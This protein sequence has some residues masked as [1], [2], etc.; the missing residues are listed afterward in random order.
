MNAPRNQP[1]SNPSGDMLASDDL[2]PHPS[3]TSPAHTEMWTL[4]E[5][6]MPDRYH[7]ER[8]LPESVMADS[9]AP[10]AP[11]TKE[12]FATG[13]LPAGT[14]LGHFVIKSFIGGGGMGRVY[15]ATDK[16][17]D[18][19]VAIKVLTR[20]KANDR[21]TVARFVNE[22]KSAARLNHEHI[23]QV[24]FT[25]E[26]AGIPYIVFEYVEGTNIRSMVE[27]FDAFPLPQ[28]LNYLIQVAHALGHAAEHG[29]I[30][31][32]IKPSNILI[33]RE[34][35]A[36]LIDMGLARLLHPSESQDDLTASGVTLGTF[37]YIS[38]EQARDPRNA[39]IRSDI[40]SL[41]C[42][43]FYMLCG[44]P[45]FPEGTVLQKLLQHQGDEPP[46]V[47]EF[48]P[49]IPAEVAGLIQKMMAKDP[50]LRFQTPHAL[51]ESL[52]S[53]A[54]M[55][56]LQPSGPG[57]LHW[58]GP[59]PTRSSVLLHHLPWVL[60]ITLLLAA[61]FLL[62]LFS[63]PQR[64]L[65]PPPE[66]IVPPP[67]TA[68]NPASS[69]SHSGADSFP[70][71]ASGS[72]AGSGNGTTQIRTVADTLP[73]FPVESYT[74]ARFSPPNHANLRRVSYRAGLNHSGRGVGPAPLSSVSVGLSQT[75]PPPA[76][77]L[78]ILDC[79]NALGPNASPTAISL[80]S[81]SATASTELQ[82]LCVDPDGVESASPS[83]MTFSTLAEAL[84]EAGK[85]AHIELRWSGPLAVDPMV[86]LEK[87]ITFV[88]AKGFFPVL[89]F[90]PTEPK[91]LFSLTDCE[92]EFRNLA[93][94]MHIQREIL[95]E[96]WSM[97]QLAGENRLR[98]DRCCLTI[99]NPSATGF[100]ANHDNVAFF[101]NGNRGGDAVTATS[102]PDDFWNVWGEAAATALAPI[103]PLFAPPEPN[104]EPLTL[105]ISN[106]LLRGE[107]TVLRC[108]VPQK[109]ECRA[110]N[111]FFALAMPFVRTD[112]TRRLTP[113]NLPIQLKL[114]RITFFGQQAF[115]VQMQN[116]HETLPMTLEIAARQS[117]FFL[118][119]MPLAVFRG[120]PSL[121]GALDYFKW[122][123]E[124]NF[125]QNVTAGWRFRSDPARSNGGIDYT[126]SMEPWRATVNQEA[127]A[128]PVRATQVDA[129]SFPIIRKPPHLLLPADIAPQATPQNA[130]PAEQAGADLHSFDWM[131]HGTD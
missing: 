41:G 15:L 62:N 35:R 21:G 10:I 86:L 25:G 95:A 28:A 116:S 40:Y 71:V 92:L 31:R 81:L 34:G 126:M 3:T 129:L 96:S 17:L 123:G 63:T 127:E 13:T 128:D 37:D 42:T 20:Q 105:E 75:E 53:V 23:A 76:A 77:A 49:N 73:S 46:D 118:N 52:M 82:K 112:D 91:N 11:L 51:L 32:D 88:A 36:K 113:Q 64:L 27:D 94:E 110:A 8:Y 70:T 4:P 43:F 83:A 99:R 130:T 38:P 101:R 65:S 14:S 80:I 93:I 107:A 109:I 55:L 79:Q 30:H 74:V 66:P 33:T 117:V 45:P 103:T 6:Q 124:S 16:A 100:A 69:E 125:F 120:A 2:L 67:S 85:N 19:K 54:K 106:S 111:S 57:K 56:G 29:V 24:Y 61:F 12:L 22:A 72:T 102:K 78:S 1:P 104:D 44:R 98:W 90:T 18:R 121:Q 58:N 115:V 59:P 84:A 9:T 50:R 87:R 122:S 89:Q 26:Q 114:E 68:G 47:R 119:N 97:F 5:K 48:Q 39:D 131:P 60:S 108:D 7:A